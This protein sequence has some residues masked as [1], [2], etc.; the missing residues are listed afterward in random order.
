MAD[1]D[2]TADTKD[3]SADSSST[4]PTSVTST[5]S[6]QSTSQS[7]ESTSNYASS[8]S[9]ASRG[10]PRTRS[11]LSNPL[12]KANL[13]KRGYH[14]FSV[15]GKD[16]HVDKRWKFVRELG[17][18]A[19]GIVVLAQDTISGENVAIKQVTRVFEKKELAKRALREIVL[20]RHFNHHENI[21]GLIDMDLLSPDFNE[22]Y[23]FME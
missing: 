23:L 10:R 14:T 19:Y 9:G 18:G 4:A 3:L 2:K 5:S 22:I 21:T 13:E 7:R 17:Q 1:T 8:S 11:E 12:S 16:F 6:K 20:L 15:L